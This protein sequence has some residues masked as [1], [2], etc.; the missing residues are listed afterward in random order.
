MNSDHIKTDKICNYP[1]SLLKPSTHHRRDSTWQLRLIG[2]G[3]VYWAQYMFKY[4]PMLLYAATTYTEPTFSSKM[5]WVPAVPS[6]FHNL[7]G[8]AKKIFGALRR[9][10]PPQ[11]MDE[12]SA[13]EDL[14]YVL[15][16]V[17]FYL[18]SLLYDYTAAT[19][20]TATCDEFDVPVKN[21][22]KEK[23]CASPRRNTYSYEWVA[24]PARLTLSQTNWPTSSSS[25]ISRA[26]YRNRVYD[27]EWQHE[28]TAQA[29]K[30]AAAG[31]GGVLWSRRIQRPR[32]RRQLQTT[33][34]S[35]NLL[36][37]TA[38]MTSLPTHDRLR[39]IVMDR[40]Q[41]RKYDTTSIDIFELKISATPIISAIFFS[42]SDLRPCSFSVDFWETKATIGTS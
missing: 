5:H 19:T 7:R 32:G 11:S 29:L 22:F 16:R 27:I 4:M 10:R 24:V 21:S 8:T 33:F 36:S 34:S 15:L 9:P 38:W 35:I 37:I 39:A 17:L 41:F 3:G 6:K 1:C 26:I 31:G 28:A 18:W 25:S 40:Y 30:P 2:F 23:W 13:I 42:I 12:V 14:F 20:T